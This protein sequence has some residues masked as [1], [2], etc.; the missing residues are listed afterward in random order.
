MRKALKNTGKKTK[1][2]K[3]AAGEKAQ[4]LAQLRAQTGFR[5]LRGKIRW[6]GELS[7]SRQGRF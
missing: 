5:K 4:A 1:S 2:T 6:D 3:K 7:E